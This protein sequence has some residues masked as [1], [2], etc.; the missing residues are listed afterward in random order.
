MQDQNKF[1]VAVAELMTFSNVMRDSSHLIGSQDFHVA[2]T[3]LCILLAPMAP[4]IATEMWMELKYATRQLQL[5]AMQVMEMKG[6][7]T[8]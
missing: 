2:L 4:H 6:T 8:R 5:M 3:T 1:N 7:S